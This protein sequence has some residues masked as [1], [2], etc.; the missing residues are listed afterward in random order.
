MKVYVCGPM[1]GHPDMNYPAFVAAEGRLT[2]VG[3]EVLNPARVDEHHVAI[4]PPCPCAQ[5]GFHHSWQWYMDRCLPMVRDADGL[6]VLPG[7]LKS[8]GAVQEVELAT[9][10]LSIPIASVET[11]VARHR[12]LQEGRFE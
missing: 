7:W 10:E 12:M 5:E 11:W 9:L 4:D 3:Y 6:A 8:K 1:T 2:A